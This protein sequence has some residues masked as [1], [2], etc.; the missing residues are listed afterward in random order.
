MTKPRRQQRPHAPRRVR[1]L[2]TTNLCLLFAAALACLPWLFASDT[3]DAQPAP[4]NAAKAVAAR[5]I[6]LATNHGAAT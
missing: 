6:S 1:R 5:V 4:R 3:T 2:D